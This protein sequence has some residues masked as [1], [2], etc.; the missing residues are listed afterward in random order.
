MNLP[1]LSDRI[2]PISPLHLAGA[3]GARGG[4][5]DA[6]RLEA[7]AR[8]SLSLYYRTT[9]YLARRGRR[10]GPAPAAGAILTTSFLIPVTSRLSAE[11][12]CLRVSVRRRSPPGTPLT[13]LEPHG[14]SVARC[15]G[16]CAVWAG[17]GGGS[18]QRRVKLKVQGQGSA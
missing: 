2:S 1:Y 11:V 4:G 16:V 14:R 18:L 10:R 5:G 12:S 3:R 15:V 9:P 7:G 13:P 17:P 8:L 6:R